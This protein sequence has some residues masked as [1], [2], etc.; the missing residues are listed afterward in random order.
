MYERKIE[1]GLSEST[2]PCPCRSSLL[3]AY[4]DCTSDPLESPLSAVIGLE[5]G[6]KY[7]HNLPPSQWHQV[8]DPPGV[9]F[10]LPKLVASIGAAPLPF[11]PSPA[12]ASLSLLAGPKCGHTGP[13]W[14]FP[15]RRDTFLGSLF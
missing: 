6:S 9:L 3:K 13:N 1:Y 12:F 2:G 10:F 5:S 7:S 14:G 4:Y 11:L 8:V 15:K